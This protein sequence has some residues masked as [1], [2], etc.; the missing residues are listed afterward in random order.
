M[1]TVQAIGAGQDLGA[2]NDLTWP[3][4]VTVQVLDDDDAEDLQMAKNKNQVD[5]PVPGLEDPQKTGDPEK[6]PAQADESEQAAAPTAQGPFDEV[7]FATEMAIGSL[8]IFTMLAF[9]HAIRVAVPRTYLASGIIGCVE[10]QLQAAPSLFYYKSV[11]GARWSVLIFAISLISVTGSLSNMLGNSKLSIMSPIG[12][13]LAVLIILLAAKTPKR[14][15]MVGITGILCLGNLAFVKNGEALRAQLLPSAVSGMFYP[16]TKTVFAEVSCMLIGCVQSWTSRLVLTANV[17]M[18]VL[19]T[20]I[21]NFTG[22]LVIMK[23]PGSEQVREMLVFIGTMIA[24]E[25]IHR[26]HLMRAVRTSC[27]RRSGTTGAVSNLRRSSKFRLGYVYITF[28]FVLM[29]SLLLV[30]LSTQEAGYAQD[31]LLWTLF[32]VYTAIQ[33]LLDV[34][35]VA[36]YKL[37]GNMSWLETISCIAR[38]GEPVALQQQP[39]SS[40]LGQSSNSEQTTAT[41]ES[42]VVMRCY[43]RTWSLLYAFV[44]SFVAFYINMTSL[45]S[46]CGT[47]TPAGAGPCV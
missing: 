1:A 22:F 24:F 20:E 28:F 41:M 45:F 11:S 27:C 19:Y 46:E 43:L 26:F 37:K 2:A 13:C 16:L 9:V 38:D 21:M 18:V 34:I 40:E 6:A 14:F 15:I 31:P 39:Q 30:S 8:A 5:K 29:P 23:S 12:G 33:L 4:A 42:T 17:D 3:A 44:M 35:W 10:L 36:F 32:G 25:I 47:L 7:R